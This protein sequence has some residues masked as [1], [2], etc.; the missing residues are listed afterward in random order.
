M[1]PD[2]AQRG[3]AKQRIANGMRQRIAVRVACR[4]FLEGDSHSA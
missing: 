1:P 2:V 3:T 4:T